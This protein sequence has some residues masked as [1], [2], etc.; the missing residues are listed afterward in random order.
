MEIIIW[1]GHARREEGS[2]LRIVLENTPQGKR[3]LRRPR[4]G[5]QGKRGRKKI[6]P[7]GYWKLLALKRENWKQLCWTVRY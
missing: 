7:G 6:R 5:R 3:S 2:L 4:F 1:V